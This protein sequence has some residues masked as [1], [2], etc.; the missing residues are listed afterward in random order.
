VRGSTGQDPISRLEQ[1]D[2]TVSLRLISTLCLGV[3]LAATSLACG[4]DDDESAVDASATG[5]TVTG[6]TREVTSE[7]FSPQL[8][9]TLSIP[10]EVEVDEPGVFALHRGVAEGIPEGEI[11]ILYPRFVFSHDGLEQ[12]DLPP[13]L[14]EWLKSHPRLEVLA[15]RDVTI[16]GL[17]GSELELQSDELDAWALFQDDLG[18]A[19]VDYNEHFLLNILETADGPLVVWLTPDQPGRFDAFIPD[20]QAVVDSIQFEQ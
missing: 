20:A 3:I 12:E 1:G 8:T 17:Y 15:E 5:A 11:G 19:H 9:V 7:K 2:P 16:G 18:E 4:D 13:D 10:W 14:V 6:D